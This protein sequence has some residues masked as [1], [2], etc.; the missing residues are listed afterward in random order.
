MTDRALRKLPRNDRPHKLDVLGAMLMVG[1]A[2]SLML[3]MSWG[4]T[5]YGWASWPILGLLAGVGGAV[6]CCSR[7]GVATAPE[8]FIPLTDAARADRARR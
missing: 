8:P 7:C 4:G 3:A 2:L 5:R 6:G 1:A